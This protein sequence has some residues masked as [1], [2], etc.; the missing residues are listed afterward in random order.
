YAWV[1]PGP[2]RQQVATTGAPEAAKDAP[3]ADKGAP[4][5]PAPMQAPQ[6]PP[7]TAGPTR[8]MTQRLA[9]VEEDMHEIRGALGEQ[10]EVLD[11]MARNFS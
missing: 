4:T 2:E 5:I 9:R 7:P 11:S 8:T 6:P 10:R 3:V 1:A